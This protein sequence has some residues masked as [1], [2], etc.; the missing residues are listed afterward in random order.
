MD[1]TTAARIAARFIELT[2]DKRRLFWEKMTA[3][4]VSL[5]QF[6]ILPRARVAGQRV[7]VS[8]A[9]QRQWVITQLAP[10]S[11]AYHVAGGLWLTGELNVDALRASFEAIVA[12][13][14]VLRTRFVANEAGEL[15]AWVDEAAVLDW[16]DELVPVPGAN[17][18]AQSHAQSHA[19]ASASAVN[20]DAP[21]ADA[22]DAPDATDA[23]EA[24][25]RALADTPFDLASGALLRAGL[26]RAAPEPASGQAAPARC[27]LAISMHHIVS[28]GWSVQVLL[29]ELVAHYRARVLGEPLAV[30]VPPIQYADYAAWQRE[31]L[32]AG[33]R[34]RQLAYW[35]RTLGST[36][37]VLSLPTDGARS[38]QGVYRA[39]RY[40]AALP[41]ALVP[42][43]KA[44][45][46]RHGTTPFTVL[47]AAFQALLHRYSGQSEIRVGVPVA[48]RHRVETEGLIGFFVNT[49]VMHAQ[50]DGNATLGALIEAMREASVGAQAHQDLPFDVLVDALRPERS[51]SHSPLFQAMCSYR[52]SD[53][54]LL[55]RLPGVRVERVALPVGETEFELTLDLVEQADGTW[56]AEW[57]VADPLFDAA[58]VERLIAHWLTLLHAF[59]SDADARVGDVV[60]LGAAEQA[61]LRAWAGQVPL[62]AP[63]PVPVTVRLAELAA[64]AP[65]APAVIGALVTL[66]RGELDARATALARRLVRDGVSAE[67]PVVV[68]M[69][70]TPEL[71]VALLAIL[72]AGGAYVPLDPDYPSAR[73]AMM[74]TDSGATRVLVDARTAATLAVPDG[75]HAWRV[76][77]L[78]GEA[79]EDGAPGTAGAAGAAGAADAAGIADARRAPLDAL[80]VPHAQ[81][82]AYLVYTSGS[83]G[84]PKGVAVAHGA[85]A[86]HCA[87]ITERYGIRA[88]DRYLHFASISFDAAAEQ[89]LVPLLAGASLVARDD[90]VWSPARL[91]Q[92]IREQ[93][94]T[95]IDLPPAYI[96]AFVRDPAA[97]DARVRVAIVGGDAWS[98]KRI[99]AV[100]ECLA[101]QRVFNAY[102]PSE[103]VITPTAWCLDADQPVPE[104]GAH[105]PIGRPLGRRR[106]WVLDARMQPVPAGVPGELYLG[107]QALARGYHARASLSAE[108][109][110]PDPFSEVPGARLYR[111][112]DAVRWRADGEL[113]FLGRVDQ[114]IKVRG[115][116]IEPGEIEARLRAQPGVR[117]AVVV[118]QAGPGGLRLVGY[119]SLHDGA[120][121]DPAGWRAAL[122]ATLPD[123]MVP[124]VFVALD[125]LP[126]NAN[127]KIDRRALPAPPTEAPADGRAPSGALE[128]ALAAIW[129]PLLRRETIGRDDNFFELG[130]DSILALQIVARARQAG[131]RLTPRQIFEHQT[132]AALAPQVRPLD[133][134][135]S[136]AHGAPHAS[137][138]AQAA[139][140]AMADGAPMPLMPIQSWF[141]TTLFAERNHWNQSVLLH[142]ET[143]PDLERLR[144]A[145]RAVVAAHP[146][147]RLRFVPPDAAVAPRVAGSAEPADVAD[148]AD[149]AGLAWQARVAALE[150]SF[151][152]AVE[153]G[154]PAAGIDA[155]CEA[156]QRSLDIERGPLCAA[157]VLGI[158]D[159]SWRVAI[160]IH[161]LAVDTVSWRILLGDLARA[162]ASADARHADMP[163]VPAVPVSYAALARR[164]HDAARR[165]DVAASV[166]AWC[167]IGEAE[168]ALPKAARGGVVA[169]AASG[170]TPLDAAA[171]G[172]ES[173]GKSGGA[174]IPAPLE[175][176]SAMLSLD[177][178][179]TRR[180]QRDACAAYR[181]TLVDL[182]L[183]ATGRVLGRFAGRDTLRIDMEG[184]GRDVPVG[185]LDLSRTVG[186]F[187]S[188]YPLALAPAGEL[189]AAIKRVK[190]ARRN[191]PH[192]GTSFAMLRY[193]GDAE[194]RAALAP[195]AD[196]DVLFNYL[197]QFDGTLAVTGQ[198]DE[199]GGA[200]ESAESVPRGWRLSA[201]RGGRAVGAAN[202][203]THALDIAAQVRDG[204]LAIELRHPGGD[205]YDA[206]T[207]EALAAEL[208]RELDAVLAHCTSGAAGLTPA[209][210]PLAAIDQARLDALPV[211]AT[212]LADLYPLA[213][214]QAGIVFHSLLGAQPGAYVNQLRVDV[215]GLDA[216]RFEAA[217]TAVAAR[218]EILRTGFLRFD[219]L[220]RQWVARRI[221]TPFSEFDWRA[222]ADAAPLAAR[223]ARLAADDLALGFDL[224][225]PPLWR[226]TL[227]RTAEARHHFVWTFHHA[228]LDGWSAAQ[229]LA[230]VLRAY[231][232]E[233][234]ASAAPRYRDFIAWLDAQ[235]REAGVAWWRART[236]AIDGPTWLSRA[237]PAPL[238]GTVDAAGAPDA[239]GATDT[240]GAADAADAADT[241]DTAD[242][243]GASHGS[244][245]LVCD[246]ARTARLA[247]LARSHRAT[248]NALVQA[249]WLV[250]LQRYTGQRTVAF[251][252]TVAGRPDT[253][254]GAE[255]MLGL[256][257]NTIV[258]TGTPTPAMRVADWLEQVQRDGVAAREH[259]H[260]PLADVQRL[261][262]IEGGEALFDTLLVFENYPV[263][264]ILDDGAAHGLRF[265]GLHNEDRTSYALTLSVSQRRLAGAL[266][267]SA[268]D[269]ALEIEFAYAADRF[270]HAQVER[271][272]AQLGTL[273]DAFAADPG[274]PLGALD[275]LP[276]GER[277]RLARWGRGADAPAQPGVPGRIAA[278]AARRPTA[279][280]LVLDGERL[281]YGT[282]E[283]R[284]TRVA[285]ALR[286]AGVGP[287]TRVGIAIERSI[288]MIVA[289]LGVLKAGGAYVPLDPSYPAER[290]AM[291]IEDSGLAL[292]LTEQAS[293][294]ERARMPVPTLDIAALAEPG[295]AVPGQPGRHERGE[296]GEGGKGADAVARLAREP[297]PDDLAYLIYTSGSTGRPKGVGITHD[298]LARHT[299]ISIE[300]FRIGETDRVLQFSTFNFDGFVEQVFPALA[301]GAT[302]VMRGPELWS[303]ERFAAEVEREGVSVA[304]L[305]TA[306]WNALA[307]DFAR[308]PDT[309]RS[310]ASLR[311]VH[312]G[313]EAMPADGVRAW[314]AAGLA[315]IELA[316]TYGPS[317]ATVTA[318]RFVCDAYTLDG[319][320]VPAQ[321]PL[322]APLPGR[323]LAVLDAWGNPAPIGAPGELCIGGPLLARGYHDRPGLTAERFVADPFSDTP[324]ARLYRTGDI[325]R[326]D[327]HGRLAY[328]GRADHQVKIRGFRIELGEIEAALL[329]EASVREAAVITRDGASGTR[330]L[331]YVAP[332]AGT[333][334]D[335]AALRAA[336]AARL[337]EYMVP[338]AVVVLEALPL[339]P[340]GKIE[341]RAL[342]E[343][344][345]VAEQAQPEALPRG[346]TET[347]L[348]AI[349][350][351][352]L[353]TAQ[354]RRTDRFFELG[355]HSLAAMQVQTAIRAELDAD[356]PLVELMRNPALEALAAAIDAERK[357]AADDAA[358]A[359]E[360]NDIL[361]G[362]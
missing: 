223:L 337:P 261:A 353:G 218:H 302:L 165:P 142:L 172:G 267:D 330:L 269:T 131:Y 314:R 155:A 352:V 217:W 191:V 132:I 62:A 285:L 107:G 10:H 270:T 282:L 97:R 202:A 216:A 111:T 129:A 130:G 354:V 290:L 91:A 102:G 115:F 274:A 8:H 325:V 69:S 112:G 48:N 103:A 120:T 63:L 179:T 350:S 31:W 88:G 85:L 30:P 50:V 26:Y 109:F 224:A 279:T 295:A 143:A 273:L 220:P 206:A 47:L 175:P 356:V 196:A 266:A 348:A 259:E 232:G 322:G 13:H 355:G 255:R 205:R 239:P 12:R 316:N 78:H 66:T 323:V 58:T 240:A 265:S 181:T 39:G 126:L 49:Q 17:A 235:P 79:G 138:A 41:A 154:V 289:M 144:R 360:L 145:W 192:G 234:P 277:V 108:R 6:P 61:Q 98:R 36:H 122:A 225:R 257:I 184:H 180:L 186:W 135:A 43:L 335:G 96:D 326:W 249:A 86:S 284:A 92:T 28:D 2:P 110:V 228:L 170:M 95:V 68:A 141:L 133:D 306:Y 105:A 104:H 230:E 25:A 101:P 59:V 271:L 168:A 189:G 300:M 114:Q 136:E 237:L 178:E 208:R 99:A 55:D 34:E 160:V 278:Q 301:A 294:A 254:P 349:W 16:R 207:L 123:Y 280:A 54:R 82:L 22:P 226:V 357:P 308:R 44:C 243:G 128:Q 359:A 309:V 164:L 77:E 67:T 156:I 193:L 305:T 342:P 176:V 29:E 236:A 151:G 211:A 311:C 345:L 213:P 18:R 339:N 204:A 320:P 346:E 113:E 71:W 60:L 293:E 80:P 324:G 84:T 263:D 201:E 318:T 317:E 238:T 247:G 52:R 148:V 182:L 215:D 137:D 167:A 7:A 286:A 42:A 1:K 303:S 321:I 198:A 292:A 190:E 229:L 313:G 304:D 38:A 251:G 118:A 197:G 159:G 27:L 268:S 40:P 221:D 246:A 188:V 46:Q 94:I 362:L 185:E 227:V 33:E 276:A 351:R 150:A 248:L 153:Q 163:S 327:D 20:A 288:G 250:L 343:P 171:T 124:G 125:A 331:A 262:G 149:V 21:D 161:H 338:A 32:E 333:V 35:T 53:W 121:A 93:G 72:K 116:R 152:V 117:D 183:V 287:D 140:A 4:G 297:H 9:Q 195:I 174:S 15:E 14:D 24:A 3:D 347:A 65:D 299:A 74:L 361:A 157:K 11:R 340:N 169:G 252:A 162:Y 119:A 233:V 329:A 45:A 19:A 194:A 253:L 158:D 134:A 173:G 312:A 203:P 177:R 214:M 87:A 166:A 70:R 75:V 296:G 139:D 332:L 147:L 328:L 90:E 231:R 283:R 89:W 260:L 81:Q 212:E 344:A 281:D 245:R 242:A 199:S 209:D 256:F 83:T 272:A 244:V 219:D 106:A 298:A 64:A 336:L 127:G 307:Q 200:A 76:D 341:R 210:V 310:L 264:A 291:M 334:P 275:P 73:L 358:F 51:L 37:P 319:A 315:A 57:I 146:A 5:A 187:T 23:L 241:A 56:E 222:S 100:R 258:V